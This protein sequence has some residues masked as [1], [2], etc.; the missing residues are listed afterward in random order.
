MF[1]ECVCGCPR[2]NHRPTQMSVPL[3]PKPSGPI[4][5]VGNHLTYNNI[6]YVWPNSTLERDE[7]SCGRCG[8]YER[9]NHAV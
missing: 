5:P 7:C 9:D 1:D 6:T 3:R 2:V 4:Y 8:N